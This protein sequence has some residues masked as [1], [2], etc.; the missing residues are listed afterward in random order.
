MDQQGTVGEAVGEAL[1]QVETVEAEE[2]VQVETDGA[3]AAEKVVDEEIRR[4]GGSIPQERFRNV[5]HSLLET[6]TSLNEALIMVGSI[7]FEG[8]SPAH[9]LRAFI[10]QEFRQG[11]LTLPKYDEATG[12]IVWTDETK[13]EWETVPIKYGAQL[14]KALQLRYLAVAINYEERTPEKVLVDSML[15]DACKLAQ[16]ACLGEGAEWQPKTTNEIRVML[17][18]KNRDEWFDRMTK[19]FGPE[20]V[21]DF[22]REAAAQVPYWDIVEKEPDTRGKADE[23]PAAVQAAA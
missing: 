19:Q 11:T 10:V 17:S 1:D 8:R 12:K 5:E 20:M 3:D 21:Y 18:S 23:E 2:A 4:V 6:A 13:T 22:L 15:R 14:L 16:T 9:E 7:I